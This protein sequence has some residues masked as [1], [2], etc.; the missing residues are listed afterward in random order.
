VPGGDEL[1]RILRRID[2]RG[3]R[4]YRDIGGDFEL[5][6]AGL[7]V[8]RVQ[9]DPFAAPS[10]LRVR[11]PMQHAALSRDLFESRLRRIA[12]AD[13]LARRVHREIEGLSGGRRGSGKSGLVSVDA[14]GQE[15]LERSAVVLTRDWVEVRLAVGLP[16]AGRRVLG[17]EAEALLM[18]D[19]PGVAERGLCAHHLDAETLQRFVQCVENQEAIRECLPSLGLVAFVGDGSLLPRESGASDRPMRRSE[20]VAFESPTSLRVSLPLAHPIPGEKGPRHEIQGLGIR[21]GVTLIAGGGYHGKSTLLRALERGVHP[22]V[23][24]DGREWVVSAPGLVKIR[25]EDGRRVERVDIGAFI[26]DLPGGR[27]T[28]A[29]TSDDASGS[30]SQ[31]AS[32]VEAVEAGATGLLLDEDTSATNFMVRDARMQALVAR[33]HEPITPFLDRVREIY[34]V[35][36]VSTVLVMGGC[37][38]YFDVADTV[39]LMRDYRPIDATSEARAIA[40]RHASGRRLE[41]KA[42]LGPVTQRVPV[43]ESFDASRGRRDVKIDAKALDLILYGREPIDLR[44]VEQLVDRSQT[45][46]IGNAIHL[47]TQRFMDGKTTLC[48]VLDALDALLD[49]E[50]LDVLD[51]FHHPGRHPGDLARPRRFEIAAAINRL[52]SLRMRQRRVRV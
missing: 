24:N 15:V 6:D 11:I 52:R 4:A 40:K 22:H 8:D 48:E 29:F 23:P 46:A 19:V 34:D 50:G 1:R 44:G 39:I 36:G 28:Q 37:G 32:I 16:A 13:L 14:G 49:A 35:H 2:G 5:G 42:P 33:E 30:T 26:G 31:A 10:K 3:Y 51:P 45:R 9:G 25:A 38:D 7:H 20:A 12:L 17:R 18:D 41:T 27:S 43:A 21:T 47:A